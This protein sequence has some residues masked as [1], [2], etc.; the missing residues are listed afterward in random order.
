MINYLTHPKF[1]YYDTKR[2][3]SQQGGGGG[4]ST[5]TSRVLEALGTVYPQTMGITN[6][7]DICADIVLIEPLAVCA[8]AIEREWR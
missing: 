6:S 1:L 8:C 7:A 2:L 3:P 4:M 5:K